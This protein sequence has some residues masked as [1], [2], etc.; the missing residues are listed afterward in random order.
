[1]KTTELPPGLRWGRVRRGVTWPSA[2]ALAGGRGRSEPEA[3]LP[4]PAGRGQQGLQPRCDSAP[5]PAAG[6]AG[7]E[8]CPRGRTARGRPRAHI[9]TPPLLSPKYTAAQLPGRWPAGPRG[10]FS[11]WG[12]G[13][14]QPSFPET[15]DPLHPEQGSPPP[16]SVLSWPRQ[17][18]QTAGPGRDPRRGS[19][20]AVE[21]TGGPASALYV[22]PSDDGTRTRTRPAVARSHQFCPQDFWATRRR[23]GADLRLSNVHPPRGPSQGV[24]REGAAGQPGPGSTM[25]RGLRPGEGTLTSD[26]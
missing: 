23:L 3:R 12:Q 11:R 4:G 17:Q 10:S 9:L 7:Q 24:G 8:H 6:L 19:P 14:T 25:V 15:G 22:R 1:M 26:R 20:A 13:C 2:S 18:T 21:G 16:S 5:S